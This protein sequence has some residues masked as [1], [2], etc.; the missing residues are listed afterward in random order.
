MLPE[1]SPGV[2]VIPTRSVYIFM[3]WISH[4]DHLSLVISTLIKN[5]IIKV[6]AGVSAHGCFMLYP[7]VSLGLELQC[8]LIAQ[9]EV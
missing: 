6:S 5:C 8:S 7:V 3:G 2:K 1:E 9:E 4:R